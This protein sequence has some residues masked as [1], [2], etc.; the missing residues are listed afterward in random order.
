MNFG[1]GWLSACP[2][3]LLD[4]CLGLFLLGFR[5]S[6]FFF[7]A[8]FTYKTKRSCPCS[9]RIHSPVS[10]LHIL[11]KRR[12]VSLSYNNNYDEFLV[13]HGHAVRPNG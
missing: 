1:A 3:T 5:V 7:N 11:L 10:M 2:W 6:F 8:C 9:T 12:K 4:S 13:K